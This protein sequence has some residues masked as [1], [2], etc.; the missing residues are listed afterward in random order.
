MKDGFETLILLFAAA[1]APLAPVPLLLDASYRPSVGELI[2]LTEL[3][4]GLLDIP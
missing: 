3:V 1:L 2:V 4:D